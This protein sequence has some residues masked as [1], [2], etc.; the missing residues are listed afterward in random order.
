MATKFAAFRNLGL[1]WKMTKCHSDTSPISTATTARLIAWSSRGMEVRETMDLEA[2]K[3]MPLTY[4]Q[5]K[6]WA[7]DQGWDFGPD[8]YDT[9]VIQAEMLP[10]DPDSMPWGVLAWLMGEVIPSVKKNGCYE[11]PE[12]L[13]ADQLHG[14]DE[15]GIK[16]TP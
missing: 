10:D 15:K 9:K 12:D 2:K 5:I 6:Q 7:D 1:P 13:D 3:K 8:G 11:W 16:R 14:R 4:R